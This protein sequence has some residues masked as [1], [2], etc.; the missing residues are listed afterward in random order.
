MIN[1][2]YALFSFANTFALFAVKRVFVIIT[3]II[4]ISYKVFCQNNDLSG[5][6]TEIAEQLAA[7]DSD[8]EAAAMFVEQLNELS[9]NPVRMNSGDESEL[10]RL[11]FLS[12]F[13]IR[14]IRD[15]I[16]NSGS[17][18]SSFEIAS[19][20]GFDRQITEMMIPFISLKSVEKDSPGKINPW[21][22][23]VTNFIIKPGETD[24]S[25]PGSRS[26][27]LSKYRITA[28]PF[29]SGLT[30]EKDA[31]EKF[32]SGSPPLPDFLSSYFSYSGKR[33]IRKII[34]GDFSACFGQGTNINTRMRQGF[35]T[36][37][38]GYM[39]GRD[40]IKPYTSSDENN[41]FR[42][43]AMTI[44]ARDLD[45]SLFCSYNR[46]D[47]TV[48]MSADSAE[49]HVTNFYTSGLHNSESLLSKKD[50]IAETSF[51]INL[52]Y[53]LQAVRLGL[54]WSE[55]RFSLPLV[56]N[57]SGPE[58]IYRFEGKMNG[59]CSV[60][61]NSLIKRILLFGE[62][63]ADYSLDLA[64]V[65]GVTLR[66]S[67][68]L[69]IN[70]LYRSYS[71]GFTSFN[72]RGP[73]TGSSTANESGLLGNFTFEAAKHLFITAGCDIAWFPW[74]K[75]HTS[76]PSRAVK[77]ELKIRYV[78]DE[79]FTAEA[80]YNYRF[81]M[82]DVNH[83]QGI[84][85]V[86]EL[87]SRTL[88]GIIK[89]SPLERITLTTRADYKIVDESGSTGMLLLQDI[90]LMFRQIPVTIRIRHCIFST[91]DWDSRIYAYE[92]D[93]LYSFSIPA[94]SGKGCRTYLIAEWKIADVA[95]LRVKYGITS[96]LEEGNSLEE[97][98]EMKMQFRIRF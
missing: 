34:V 32:L 24:T 65:Q 45:L 91:D 39:T 54:T 6:I 15:H 89:Y 85:G 59:V 18:V 7:D 21:N 71:P 16:E 28:G 78:P 41:F 44:S 93:L 86:S 1:I 72:G 48:S 63:S 37:A 64:M 33:I 98:D 84:A 51:G 55:S 95:E 10:A 12:D 38:S 9:E 69:S 66:P 83:E 49:M 96:L 74:L 4:L 67:D 29:S 70:F 36:I 31:G 2:L 20:P 58:D 46:T 43:A 80:S 25:S 11:F 19:I 13:Q 35:S 94:L 73:G 5:T 52:N 8:T 90:S 57:G 81:S 40:E 47:A 56:L 30:I 50:A 62:L 68:R 42:G 79:I 88:K 87:T 53:N 3:I 27:V 76:F 23:L 97:K 17:I 77:R 92:N 26:K 61:Y 22:A 60:Y 75:Y 14:A 82:S